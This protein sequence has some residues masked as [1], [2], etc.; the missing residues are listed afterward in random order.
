M[1]YAGNQDNC[2]RLVCDD[3]IIG[4]D[5]PRFP[6]SL[7]ASRQSMAREV[8]TQ[9]FH[10]RRGERISIF[11]AT[12]RRHDDRIE[13]VQA[14]LHGPEAA[15]VWSHTA[16]RL[17]RCESEAGRHTRCAG[18]KKTRA[19][20]HS[21]PHVESPKTRCQKVYA[22]GNDDHIGTRDEAHTRHDGQWYRQGIR[23]DQGKPN[24]TTVK[25]SR[26]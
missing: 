1:I 24:E 11:S 19:R 4:K 25:E 7:R 10:A 9:A 3:P 13:S 20:R 18:N 22:R 6:K 21:C 8:S 15:I 5:R 17:E 14:K 26:R 2:K 12:R 16:A 23:Q